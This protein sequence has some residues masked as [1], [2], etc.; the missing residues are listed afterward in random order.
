M[1]EE[2]IPTKIIVN[3]EEMVLDAAPRF[4]CLV[5]QQGIRVDIP[6]FVEINSRTT[7]DCMSKMSQKAWEHI[8]TGEL[9]QH[10]FKKVFREED[11]NAVPIPATIDALNKG[12]FGVI[13]VAGMI[14]QGCE[15]LFEG[16]TKLFFRNPED[17]LHPKAERTIVSMFMEMQQLLGVG[18]NVQVQELPK[19]EKPKS[20]RKRK[21]E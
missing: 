10:L 1:P 14:V 11:D 8:S 12:D 5:H 21:K 6:E 7:I 2:T 15:A 18:E 4:T 13:H 16:K 19:E 17:T 9:F 20:K 3:G